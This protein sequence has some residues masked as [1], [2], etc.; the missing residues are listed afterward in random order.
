MNSENSKTLKPHVLVLKDIINQIE[1]FVKR[2]LPYEI[3]AF[4][5]HEKHK[6]LIQ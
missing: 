4:I 3:V 6:K 5:T 2:L 1:E